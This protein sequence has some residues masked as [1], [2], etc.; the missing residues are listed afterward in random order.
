MTKPPASSAESEPSTKTVPS[1]KDEST[2]ADVYIA[3]TNHRVSNSLSMVAAMLRHKRRQVAT[4][5]ASEALLEA[6]ARIDGIALLHKHLYSLE[7]GAPVELISFLR[8]ISARITESL[9]TRI[10][11]R[12]C[13]AEVTGHAATDIAVIVTELCLNAVK[14]AHGSDPDACI[15]VEIGSSDGTHLFLEVRDT[16]PGLPEGFDGS[17]PDSM[18]MHIVGSLAE[19]L[20]GDLSYRN[21]SGAVVRLSFRRP[22]R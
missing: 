1:S 6:S 12:G 7:P 9:G 18:G 13:P 19:G 15:S 14:H 4:A 20:G 21:D 3:E 11:V 8:S 16:G 2:G 22:P 17:A 5:E 10:E